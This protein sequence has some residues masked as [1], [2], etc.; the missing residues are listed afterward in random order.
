MHKNLF[1]SDLQKLQYLS[2]CLRGDAKTAIEALQLTQTNYM[3]ALQILKTRYQNKRILIS[4]LLNELTSLPT[5]Q[6]DDLKKS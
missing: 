5:S 3:V 4:T 6:I 2:A 1:L